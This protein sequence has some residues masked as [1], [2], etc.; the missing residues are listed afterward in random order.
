MMRTITGLTAIILF[1]LIAVI[2]FAYADAPKTVEVSEFPFNISIEKGGSLTLISND[3]LDR[4][5]TAQIGNNVFSQV[6]RSGESI[7]LVI[8]EYMTTDN[9]D[10]WYLQ[11][12]ITGEWSVILVKEPYVAPPPVVYVEPTPEPTV[13]FSASSSETSGTYESISNVAVYE[14]DVDL[15]TIQGKLS[16]VTSKFNESVVKISNQNK[17]IESL[18]NQVQSLT[19]NMTQ[20]KSQPL[21]VF[22]TTELDNKVSLLEANNT[23]LSLDNTKLSQDITDL[24]DDRDKWKSLAESWYGVAMEQL[25]V[26]VNILGL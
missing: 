12:T 14:G 22:D 20:L 5:F 13:I 19:A 11:D 21:V 16:E 3:A 18:N 2:G 8:P 25:K 17:E 7:T 26:M 15:L 1:S 4:N 10:G 24:S 6:L 9:T 23:K